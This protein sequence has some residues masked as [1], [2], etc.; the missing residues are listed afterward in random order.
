M[1]SREVLYI[2]ELIYWVPASIVSGY[3]MFKHGFSKQMGWYSLTL[4][5]I[6]RIIGAITGILV[7]GHPSEGLYET[8]FIC[9]S[10][11]LMALIGALS[12]IM[13]RVNMNMSEHKIITP[14]RVK[15]IHMPTLAATILSICAGTDIGNGR[16]R[17]VAQAIL[18]FKIATG[19]ITAVYLVVVLV[20]IHTVKYKRFALNS[21][22]LFIKMAVCSIPLI[23]V[24]LVFAW[25]S[26]WMPIG[27][28]FWMMSG[29]IT[30][31]II[32]AFMS[33]LEEFIVVSMFLY[34]GLVTENDS[35]PTRAAI[36][37]GQKD[38]LFEI[39]T[40][41]IVGVVIARGRGKEL[42]P[43]STV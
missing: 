29:G 43:A 11:G 8:T 28:L 19:I 4:L 27:S 33:V 16:P 40:E 13:L 6:F 21:E 37:T 39:A 25:L 20:T 22:Q 5:S 24:R 31:T 12:G 35:A 18:F 3:V 10:V 32:R 1:Q 34:A 23:T 30:P 9:A 2:I 17:D 15:I 14:Q 41:K 36:R 7:I 26:H 38:A 42:T